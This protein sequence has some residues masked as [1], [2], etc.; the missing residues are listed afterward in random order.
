MAETTTI[1]D[2]LV[3]LGVKADPGALDLVERFDKAIKG[4]TS[5]VR[6]FSKVA[7]AGAAGFEKLGASAASLAPLITKLGALQDK[8]SGLK[9]TGIT[10]LTV[11]AGGAG[12]TTA[13]AHVPYRGHD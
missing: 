5:S 4:I 2:L 9:S 8:L 1:A 13:P 10:K 11:S 6:S 12:A 7:D 3:G